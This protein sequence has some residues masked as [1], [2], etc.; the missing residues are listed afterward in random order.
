MIPEMAETGRRVQEPVS[1]ATIEAGERLLDDLAERDFSELDLLAVWIDGIQLGTYHV[2]CTV[3]VDAEG[4]KH[5]L[6]L[7]EGATENA[8]V[9][10]ALLRAEL[11][12]AWIRAGSSAA[13]R[14]R[15]L[16][17]VAV[18]DRR[19]VRR[20]NPVQ[21]CRTHR[22]HNVLDSCRKPGIAAGSRT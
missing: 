19:G 7:R 1:R 17:G 6:G 8:E 5:V 15:R 21:R 18:A 9:A 10:T 2:I 22:L 13:V 20:L 16:Q 4:H 14:D 11:V 3:G 12:A